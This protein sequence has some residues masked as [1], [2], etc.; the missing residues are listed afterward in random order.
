M[1]TFRIAALSV[2]AILLFA[3]CETPPPGSVVFD[4]DNDPDEVV[5]EYLDINEEEFAGHTMIPIP[6]QHLRQPG[7][8][9]EMYVPRVGQAA[10][11]D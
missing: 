10:K 5:R 2:F 6:T 3:Q 7:D 8:T 1:S 4:G 11:F 9:A